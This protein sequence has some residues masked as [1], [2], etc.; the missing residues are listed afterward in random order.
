M[1]YAPAT[2]TVD[3]PE[4]AVGHDAHAH[5]HA[6]PP[7]LQHHFVS[8]E[9]QF[10]SAKMGMWLFLATEILLFSG[11]FVAYAVFRLKYPETYTACATALNTM[12]GALNTGVL[13]FSSLTV[14]L[15]I[16]AIQRDDQKA[17]R[18]NL[19]LTLVCATVF[20]IV[21]YFEYTHKFHGGIYPG[22]AFQPHGEEFGH[23]ANVP[24]ARQFFSLYYVST[25]IHAIH[26]IAGMITLFWVYLK[27]RR[28]VFSS[29]YYT[30]VELGGLYWHL[31]DVIWI[32][33]FPLLY[34]I[35]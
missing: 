31:V 33:L 1:A 24:Y 3:S 16:N 19:V 10:D 15:A 14:A 35:H 22:L 32:F 26:I 18:R 28:G 27:A 11:M 6:H 8:S 29:A 20:L 17:L 5:D 2:L 4:V 21:K 9:Q 13:L 7:H 30:H 34:L 25:G 23:L 12:Q